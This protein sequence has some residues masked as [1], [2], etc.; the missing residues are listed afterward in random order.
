MAI[1]RWIGSLL[2][3]M[4]NHIRLRVK[5]ALNVIKDGEQVTWQAFYREPPNSI[6]RSCS[7]LF[8][9][10]KKTGIFLKVQEGA[11]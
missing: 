11:N 6:L 8:W 2:L 10:M 5:Y 3:F 1:N 4:Y 9:S 7:L